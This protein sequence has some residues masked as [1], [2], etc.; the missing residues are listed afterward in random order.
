MFPK[1]AVVVRFLEGI[2]KEFWELISENL[3]WKKL[4]TSFPKLQ[5]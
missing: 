5:Y 4:W 3:I 1:D 2:L